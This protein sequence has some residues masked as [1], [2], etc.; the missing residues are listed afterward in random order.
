MILNTGL[1]TDIPAFF[2]PWFV[3][4]LRE[5]FVMVRSP[6]AP[7]SV[8]RYRIHP[9]VVDMIGFCTKNPAPMLDHM[10]LLKPY[11]QHWFVTVTPYGPDVEPHV[12]PKEQVMEDFLR[13]SRIVGPHC[14]DWR[15]DPILVDGTY[16]VEKHLTEFERMASVL[17]GAT[18]VCVISFIDLYEKVRRNFPEA[19][20]VSLADRMTL[21]R[22]MVKIA[23]RHGM[24]LKTCAEGDAYASVGADVSGCMTMETYERAIGEK[25]YPPAFKPGRKECAC[26]L[27]AD[28]GAYHTC[29]HLCRYCYANH[30][31]QTVRKNL[32]AHD[33]ASPLLVG[34]LLPEDQVH[35]AR[36]Q[37]WKDRQLSFL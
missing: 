7:H 18:Q 34:H 8:T 22:E 24:V 33:P 3:N 28:V 4:R 10:E 19:R 27:S 30:D 21:T 11:G 12:P 16:T 6:Y 25:L 23:R 26:H 37:S 32:L 14:V 13:L 2:T 17:E 36:Q 29:A 20:E 1:R 5:G 15:Y 31:A 9:D 35:Q